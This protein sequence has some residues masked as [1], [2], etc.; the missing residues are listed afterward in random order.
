MTNPFVH[1]LVFI[2][3]I[4]IPG[5]LIVYF[6]WAAA[7]RSI[8]LKAIAKQ[9]SDSGSHKQLPTP[10]EARAAFEDMFPKNS[11]RAQSRRK[12]LMRARTVRRKHSKK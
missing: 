11:L 8:S 2:T 7:R 1:A 5:G 10:S 12:Q 4:L 3:A 9:N 6:A